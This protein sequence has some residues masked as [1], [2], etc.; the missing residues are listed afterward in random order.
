[1]KIPNSVRIAGVEYCVIEH[2]HLDDGKSVLRGQ[3]DFC[4][5]KI[6]LNIGLELDCQRRCITLL[7]EIL[8]GIWY[9]AGIDEQY[10]DAEEEIVEKLAKGLYMV[11]QDNGARLFDLREA[12]RRNDGTVD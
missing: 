1:M 10:D 12:E 11:L 3:I 9:N 4:S 5:N 6:A 2:E 8:H 7:H